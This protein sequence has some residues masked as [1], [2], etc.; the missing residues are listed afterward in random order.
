M[1]VVAL[2]FMA[3]LF[4][5]WLSEFEHLEDAGFV[6]VGLVGA[7]LLLKVVNDSYVPPQWMM[8]AA[9]AILFTWGFSKRKE[10]ELSLEGLIEAPLEPME[11]VME[12][13][14]DSQEMPSEV[15]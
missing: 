5:Q 3:G 14:R 13:V 1:G 4:I 15:P 12:S 2:R 8:I 10:S 6:T 7:R 11:T 9:I